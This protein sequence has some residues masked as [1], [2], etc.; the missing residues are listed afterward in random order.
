MFNR[1]KQILCAALDD[2]GI[3]MVRFSYEGK[4]VKI[5]QQIKD[6]S[7]Q[8]RPNEPII[9]S[10]PTHLTLV[11]HITLPATDDKLI[12][13]MIPFE[14]SRHLPSRLEEFIWDYQCLSK[15]IGES[16][17]LTVAVKK[18]L[19]EDY[20]NSI[21]D[22]KLQILKITISS[23]ALFNLYQQIK[24][25]LKDNIILLTVDKS[26]AD[27]NI[28]QQG[29]LF[30]IKGIKWGNVEDLVKEIHLTTSYFNEQKP[31]VIDHIYIIGERIPQLKESLKGI[32]PTEVERI[33]I[34]RL[35]RCPVDIPDTNGI[36]LGLAYNYPLN[37]TDSL[38]LIPPSQKEAFKKRFRKR[39]I[40]LNFILLGIISVLLIFTANIELSVKIQELKNL[41]KQLQPIEKKLKIFENIKRAIA[42]KSIQLKRLEKLG[43]AKEYPL[44]VLYELTPIREK[45]Q[46]KTLL[47]EDNNIKFRGQ[48]ES[49][50]DASSMVPILQDSA[51]LENV[52]L[53]FVRKLTDGTFEFEIVGEIVEQMKGSV[54]NDYKTARKD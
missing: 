1:H 17:L 6:F 30:S 19:L 28:I 29:E 42:Q 21:A 38:N 4:R 15:S 13:D 49:N 36:L 45:M 26:W 25:Q 43:N 40:R 23:L 39:R 52:R 22:Y 53:T 44:N 9:F 48:T 2:S 24:S 20:F 33:E 10:I 3:K 31:L 32:I 46:L 34:P 35:L 50:E 5:D 11:K 12:K 37:D 14:L 54:I 41:E 8:L 47:I 16:R 7:Y 27:M 18:T 51:L